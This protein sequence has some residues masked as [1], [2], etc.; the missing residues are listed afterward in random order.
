MLSQ[1][2][3]VAASLQ[4]EADLF[5][6]VV[7]A[8]AAGS[9]FYI[10]LN[11]PPETAP[12]CPELVALIKD[13]L[14]QEF[15][16]IT[17]IYLL[18][19]ILG[20]EYPDWQEHISLL[21]EPVPSLS[22]EEIKIDLDLNF[23]NLDLDI[24]ESIEPVV[25]PAPEVK[26][27][28]FCFSRNRHLVEGDIDRPSKTVSEIL[29]S[30]HGWSHP[31]KIE[32]L[33]FL[34]EWFADPSAVA[35]DRL[36]EKAR[37]I[38]AQMSADKELQRSLKV[39][40]SRYC[41]DPDRTLRE[42]SGEVH[43]QPHKV[44]LSGHSTPS[45]SSTTAPKKVQARAPSPSKSVKSSAEKPTPTAKTSQA[46]TTDEIPMLMVVA[47][48]VAFCSFLLPYMISDFEPIGV[49]IF[50]VVVS[51]AG[52][53]A[54]AFQEKTIMSISGLILS[55]FY[56]FGFSN[57]VI[58]IILGG[59]IGLSVGIAV[60]MGMGENNSPLAPKPL[61]VMAV[62]LIVLLT[63][64][65]PAWFQIRRGRQNTVQLQ[66]LPELKAIG[67]VTYAGQTYD[68]KGAIAE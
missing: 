39:W 20:E 3:K 54:G 53:W 49:G 9:E 11:R 35:P 56:I 38:I 5:G 14:T 32:L 65:A 58:L 47:I 50:L 26:L 67:S 15:P 12:D 22:S 21:P 2:D 66:V 8:V 10:Y 6:V 40:F 25:T 17:S 52:G 18:S 24:A 23:E 68:L 29:R 64:Q 55:G 33:S 60:K 51:I 48:V 36:P 59:A 7:Q 16:E 19:R 46:F 57:F 31:H 28:T 30:F 37:A 27:N 1:A 34:K 45:P 62:A 41:F 43:S 63:I 61:R 4:L 44:K 13:K 42:I